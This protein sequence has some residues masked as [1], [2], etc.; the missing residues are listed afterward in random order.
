MNRVSAKKK[1]K[2]KKKKTNNGQ[3][4]TLQELSAKQHSE[5]RK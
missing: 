4:H 2:K 1:K 5:S 3:E